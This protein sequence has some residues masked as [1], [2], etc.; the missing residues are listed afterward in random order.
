MLDGSVVCENADQIV[1]KWGWRGDE[2]EPRASRRAR[3]KFRDIMA[4]V[5]AVVAM[6]QLIQDAD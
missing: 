5:V 1:R 4:I 6:N 3:R 2:R